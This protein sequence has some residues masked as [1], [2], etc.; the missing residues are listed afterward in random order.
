MTV[1]RARKRAVTVRTLL[2]TGREED[3]P[4]VRAFLGDDFAGAEERNGTPVLRI[5]TMERGSEPDEIPP[6]WVLIEGVRGEHYAC[7]GEIFAE[8]YEIVDADTLPP[9]DRAAVLLEAADAIEADQI[10]EEHEER[11]RRGGLTQETVLRGAAV[12][13]KAD[14]LRRMAAAQQ[15]T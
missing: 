10:R 8:T 13:A 9:A 6:G 1:A 7:E 3:L 14:L 4:A 11:A 5:R 12:R 15:V 2:W